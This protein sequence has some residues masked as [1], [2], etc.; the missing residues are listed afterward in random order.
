M[1][2]LLK[3]PL[4]GLNCLL[5]QDAICLD[6]F[7]DVHRGIKLLVLNILPTQRFL[8]HNFMRFP[9]FITPFASAAMLSAI[10]FPLSAFMNP[11]ACKRLG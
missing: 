8:V 2:K 5:Y 1:I 4:D 10:D 11:K 6:W 7:D 3:D 9:V